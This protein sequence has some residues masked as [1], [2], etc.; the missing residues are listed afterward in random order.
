MW[1]NEIHGWINVRAWQK[2][3]AF[4][5]TKFTEADHSWSR[6]TNWLLASQRGPW[7]GDRLTEASSST[8]SQR[9]IDHTWSRLRSGP[10][11]LSFVL[12]SAYSWATAVWVMTGPD[13]GPAA[14]QMNSRPDGDSR[15]A[16]HSSSWPAGRPT[17]Q[18]EAQLRHDSCSFIHYPLLFKV[19][20]QP[21]WTSDET[22]SGLK[23]LL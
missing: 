12:L 10:P 7:A 14:G 11:S 22:T 20:L 4:K 9:T 5:S 1:M 15:A 16:W 3:S 13:L 19:Q 6:L 8:S 21:P 2:L 17:E 23:R 18:T